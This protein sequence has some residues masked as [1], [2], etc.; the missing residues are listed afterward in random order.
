MPAGYRWV[1]TLS[2]DPARLVHVATDERNGQQVV[3]E[4]LPGDPALRARLSREAVQATGLQHPYIVPVLDVGDL[5]GAVYTVSPFVDG[6][7]LGTRLESG[8]LPAASVITVLGPVADAL[9][10]AHRSGLTHRGIGPRAIVLASP[11]DVP[12]LRGFGVAPE[13]GGNGE[14]LSPEQ[15]RGA[16]VGP[17][18]DVYALGARPTDGATTPRRGS[19]TCAPTSRAISTTSSR[20]RWRRTPPSGPRPAAR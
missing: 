17:R 1:G 2:H 7:D 8:P 6:P 5:D 13:T 11:N 18:A 15:V 10:L 9:D 16:P 19:A 3:V 20:G 12:C 4:V 14:D